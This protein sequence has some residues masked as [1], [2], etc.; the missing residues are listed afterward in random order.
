[1]SINN[2]FVFF[3]LQQLVNSS[4]V[5]INYFQLYIFENIALSFSRVPSDD[6]SGKS[7]VLSRR[8]FERIMS[9]SR[10][11]TKAEREAQ[12]ERI[13]KEKE[14]A[15]VNFRSNFQKKIS[16]C[17]IQNFS[18]WKSFFNFFCS[19]SVISGRVHGP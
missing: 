6:P 9:G 2:F 8:E 10:V 4:I 18:E 17:F 13:K 15:Q 11:L 14:E 12:M 16:F 7:I 1:M 5:H 3:I 19:I